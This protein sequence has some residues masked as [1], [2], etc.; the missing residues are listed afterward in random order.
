MVAFLVAWWLLTSRPEPAGFL[1]VSLR[2][3]GEASFL[4]V[5]VGVGGWVITI[6]VAMIA[7]VTVMALGISPEDL[8]P[9]PMIPWMAGLAWWKKS[10]IVISAMTV[11]EAFYRGWLQK[12]VGLVASTMIF[13][14]S[15]AGY[16]QPFMLIG[17]TTIS[18]VIGFAFYKTRNLIPC[19]VAHGVFDAIQIFVVVPVVLKFAP[20]G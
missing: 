2:D 10:L 18:F 17:V 1:N 12:R 3:F 7:G 5:G 8:Q 16:G 9:S 20:V 6:T 4:G 14:L 11:E 15:H 19:I 13:A